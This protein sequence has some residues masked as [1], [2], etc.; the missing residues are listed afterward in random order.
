MTHYHV[1]A[2]LINMPFNKGSILI[3]N[4]YLPKRYTAQKLSK[5]YR[6]KLFNQQS[7]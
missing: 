1:T 5:E 7:L 2:K 6:S 4:L 3:K